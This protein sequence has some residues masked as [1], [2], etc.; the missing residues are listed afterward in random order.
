MGAKASIHM[1]PMKR[2]KNGSTEQKIQ[3]VHRTIMIGGVGT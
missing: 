1:Q 2:V 3:M